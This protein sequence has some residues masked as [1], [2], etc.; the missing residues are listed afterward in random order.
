MKIKRLALT[1]LLVGAIGAANAELVPFSNDKGKW[2]FV[3]EAGKEV[4]SCKYDEIMNFDKGLYKVSKNHKWGVINDL[5]KEVYPLKYDA[6]DIFAPGVYRLAAGGKFKDGVVMDEKYGF[7]DP[8]GKILLKPE[9]EEIGQFHSGVAYV[10][11]GDKYGFIDRNIEFV[12]PCK[13]SAV[14][15]FNDKG[16]VWVNE[17]GK[18]DKKSPSQVLGGK[19]GVYN[20]HGKAIVPVK[21]KSFGWCAPGNIT[22]KKEA[23]DKMDWALKNTNIESGSHHFM[24]FTRVSPKKFSKIDEEAAGFWVSNT[25]GTEKNGLID[26]NGDVLVQPGKYVCA[27]YPTDGIALVKTKQG[28]CPINYLNLSTGK[29]LLPENIHDGWAFKDGY[30]VVI[31]PDSPVK[32]GAKAVKRYLHTVIDKD[33]RTVSNEYN[34][35]FAGKDGVHVV[36]GNGGYGL[37]DRNGTEILAAENNILLPPSEGLLLRRVS[38]GD[39]LGFVD[40][41]GKWVIE[42]KFNSAASF[43]Y[44]WAAVKGDEGWGYIAPDASVKVPLKWNNTK[45]LSKENPAIIFVQTTESEDSFQPYHVAEQRL[46]GTETYG[47]SRNFDSDFENVALVGK[48][49]KHIG[50]IAMDGSTIIP[51]E[52]NYDVAAKA[53]TRYLQRNGKPW[54]ATDTHRIKLENNDKRNKGRLHQKIDAELWDF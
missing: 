33:G 39:K 51:F 40:T 22:P 1:M 27:W 18:F 34:K 53:Y 45:V 5:G 13:Y 23:L 35:I 14:G 3:D 38:K 25:N 8:S 10:K 11:K 30:A 32:K 12:I 31:R 36:L 54:T 37:I 42:P 15:S 50:V 26:L 44:G 17:G 24:S 49:T 29:L 48:D 47:Y 2:G 28:F 52:F 16:Y 46:I 4:V 6:I 19:F 20:L 41:K 21:Y 9:Y 43:K 7:G